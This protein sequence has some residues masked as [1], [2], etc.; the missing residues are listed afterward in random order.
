MTGPDGEEHPPERVMAAARAAH[1]MRRPDTV[2]ADLLSD[3]AADPPPGLRAGPGPRLLTFGAAG[4]ELHLQVTVH[5]DTCDIAGQLV[6]PA[7][8]AVEFRHAGGAFHHT[9]DSDGAFVLRSLPRTP[10]SLVCSPSLPGSRPLATPWTPV[11]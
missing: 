11:R 4:V 6:P 3:S 9:S 8:S 7:R 2:L 10:F 1:R 5:G